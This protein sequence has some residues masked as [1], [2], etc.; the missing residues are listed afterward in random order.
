MNY[1]QFI[2]AMLECT[3]KKLPENVWA[4]R[5]EILKNNGVMAV[6]LA[7]RRRGESVAPL[8]YLEEFYK[9]YLLGVS[10]EELAESLIRYSEN[11]P[12]AP[13]WDY[14]CILD[15]QKIK[16]RI[17]YKL[18][19]AQKNERLLKE[20]PHLPVL[21]FAI[22]FYLMIPANTSE[23]CSVLIKNE[24]RN[25]WK[26]PI[27]VLYHYAKGNTPRLCPYQLCALNDFAKEE[28]LEELEESP[29]Y[30]LTNEKG[31]NGAAAILYPG[32]PGKIYEKLGGNYYL[33]PSTVHEFLIVPDLEEISPQHLLTMLREINETQVTKEEVLSD[34]I[35]YFDGNIITK[36]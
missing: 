14:H 18:I 20:V 21:D 33:L 17:V 13:E 4:E 34:H 23:C 28:G 32:M 11:A 8:I 35:Y 31:I 15:F 9:K 1:E 12:S 5:Q 27:S 30:V 2:C 7:I 29:F 24:H 10:V 6:G 16:N 26:L 25:L 36:M 19:H 22:I 3:N